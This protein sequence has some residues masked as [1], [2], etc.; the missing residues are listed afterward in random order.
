M[1]LSPVTLKTT[2]FFGLQGSFSFCLPGKAL[3]H[4]LKPSPLASPLERLT[5]AL[6]L[7]PR[8]R[9]LLLCWAFSAFE[10]QCHN[11]ATALVY[12]PILYFKNCESNTRSW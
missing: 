11:Y 7:S 3:M 5:A 1:K 9:Q 10:F 6:F 4:S 8:W 12:S 2:D